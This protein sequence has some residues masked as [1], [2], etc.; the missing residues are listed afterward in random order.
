MRTLPVP[1]TLAS[2]LEHLEDVSHLVFAVD[3]VIF[4]HYRLI[5]RC[6]VNLGHSM[7]QWIGSI[8]GD[9]IKLWA[10]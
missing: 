4:H 10:I 3:G 5:L 2:V 1:R 7:L 8:G 6:P 9:D